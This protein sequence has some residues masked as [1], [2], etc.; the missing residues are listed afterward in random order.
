MLRF[1]VPP[2]SCSSSQ[3][4]DSWNQELRYSMGACW[5]VR[6][7]MASSPQVFYRFARL[8]EMSVLGVSV[9]TPI[10]YDSLPNEFSYGNNRVFYI[11]TVNAPNY[12][13]MGAQRI[14]QQPGEC[15]LGD[16]AM[17]TTSACN[18]PHSTLCLGIPADAFREYLPNPEPFVGFHLDRNSTLSRVAYALLSS[19]Y[20]MAVEE[21]DDGDRDRVIDALLRVFAEWCELSSFASES[22]GIHGGVTSRQIKRLING[23]LRKPELSV[24]SIAERVGVSTRYLQLLFARDDD[25]ISSYIRRER[26]RGC[27]H[28]L[29]DAGYADKSITDIAY[30]WGFNS[31]AHFSSSFKKAYGLTAREYRH[32]SAAPSSRV[33]SLLTLAGGA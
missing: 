16:S 1:P 2:T 10:A 5:R 30:S 8:G 13:A 23:D 7:P 14:V 9:S 24:E 12:I 29:Q 26:L 4:I 15:M 28:D 6:R 22:R 27:L 31:A 21:S 19:V 18:L 11:H 33:H 32:S 20:A 3:S 17:L 25:C